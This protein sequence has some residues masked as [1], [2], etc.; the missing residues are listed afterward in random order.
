MEYYR[1]LQRGSAP[2]FSVASSVSTQALAAPDP[3]S[4]TRQ[5]VA[6]RVAA[7]RA[8]TS[9]NC[10]ICLDEI[11]LK[12]IIRPCFHQFCHLC[13][14]EWF[15][16]KTFCPV[17]RQEIGRILYNLN[18]ELEYEECS[19]PMWYGTGGVRSRTG[20][21]VNDNGNRDRGG[22]GGPVAFS[23]IRPNEVGEEIIISGAGHG[24]LGSLR[25]SP[26]MLNLID[27]RGPVH[28][29]TAEHIPAGAVP[30][31]G[32]SS[33]SSSTNFSFSPRFARVTLIQLVAVLAG[34][35]PEEGVPTRT[36]TLERFRSAAATVSWG[37]GVASPSTA[38]AANPAT[39]AALFR[40]YLY[41][42]NYRPEPQQQQ[43]QPPPPL[44]TA[45]SSG[46]SSAALV[47]AGKRRSTR[48]E[49]MRENAVARHRLTAF[50]KGELDALGRVYR[51]SVSYRGGTAALLERFGELLGL[52]ELTGAAFRESL[53][54]LLASGSN[55]A[56]FFGNNAN[57]GSGGNSGGGGEG[58]NYDLLAKV[59]SE[60]VAFA[61]SAAASEPEEY[62][63]V[64]T[65]VAPNGGGSLPPLPANSE[66]SSTMS[67]SAS[68]LTSSA[69]ATSSAATSA[70]SP[71]SEA[72]PPTL[73]TIS[74]SSP[75]AS[76]SSPASGPSSAGSSP[77]SAY[78]SSA[79][80][81]VLSRLEGNSGNVHFTRLRRRQQQQQQQQ[82]QPQQQ[83][84]QEQ[85]EPP[86][87][88]PSVLSNATTVALGGGGGGDDTP[89]SVGEA[90]LNGDWESSGREESL[91]GMRQ[92]S[93]SVSAIIESATAS[94]LMTGSR[95]HRRN[96]QPPPPPLPFPSRLPP[97]PPLPLP[98][99]HQMPLYSHHYHH[100]NDPH[101]LGL[102]GSVMRAPLLS[103]SNHW[104]LGGG[105]GGG[106]GG[107]SRNGTWNLNLPS[108][109]DPRLL[110][111]SSSF[112]STTATATA[113]GTEVAGTSA[114][115]TLSS[116]SAG[117]ATVV[118]AAPASAVSSASFTPMASTSTSLA[119]SS[120][121]A[122]S[123]ASQQQQ[124]QAKSTSQSKKPKRP[125][126]L[127]TIS[128]G[129]ENEARGGSSKR[130]KDR[131]KR[132]G[133][134]NISSS[135]DSEIEWIPPVGGKESV[136]VGLYF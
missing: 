54:E 63:R 79:S 85:Q 19:L 8:D 96:A 29:I 121:S 50:L 134:L 72:S 107:F 88:S 51:L 75:S 120:T 118:D 70:S 136:C 42:H 105:G 13:L 52:Y 26:I 32:A 128:S 77:P 27:G 53:R 111:L 17:C 89:R 69:S 132:E 125:I 55:L 30:V 73:I 5:E 48:L 82:Q 133:N 114:V 41:L 127:I 1:S 3:M 99:H 124:Q 78:S 35:H 113:T 123:A 98:P 39:L 40:A 92:A 74:S 60:L 33:S 58:G 4:A 126:E 45:T 28:Y 7:T 100:H 116:S 6:P 86:S 57:G 44:P 108:P 47:V 67:T 10:A 20:R 11:S 15:K 25:L 36:L 90:S 2:A 117:A 94:V 65:F 130:G 14:F 38:L 112:S 34:R 122:F 95:L 64:V 59:Y 16:A 62:L 102:P 115:S 129:S 37:P 43:R 104:V 46:G 110:P 66:N 56:G 21:Y 80:T 119:S 49:F 22:G 109:A 68:T 135:D 71:A 103:A 87:P 76:V 84:Q 93:A 91:S 83:E 106:G 23:I 12:V 24:S 131:K 18:S 97:P 81:I 61:G 9:H 31:P 101:H